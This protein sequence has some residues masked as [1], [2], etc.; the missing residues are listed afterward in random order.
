MKTRIPKS[1]LGAALAAHLFSARVEAATALPLAQIPSNVKTGFQ[2]G[3]G[4]LFMVGFPEIDAKIDRFIAENP[5]LLE[6]YQS[7]TKEQLIR[8]LM[9]AKMQRNEVTER[10]NGAIKAWVDEHPEMKAKIEER[11]RNLPEDKRERA[12]LNLAKSEAANQTVKSSSV[13]P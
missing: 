13:R 5:K 11:V 7:F 2:Y 8:K 6:Y 1:I 12:F 4:L 3:L 9:L 10:R